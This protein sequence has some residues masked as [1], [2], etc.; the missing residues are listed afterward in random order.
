MSLPILKIV[1]KYLDDVPSTS[2]TSWYYKKMTGVSF[3]TTAEP[4]TYHNK[5]IPK[6]VILIEGA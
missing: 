3:F 5:E 1:K 2:V 4:H 6:T